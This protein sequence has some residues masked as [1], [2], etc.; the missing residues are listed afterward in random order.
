MM[1]PVVLYLGSGLSYGLG[2]GLTDVCPS[3]SHAEN[4]IEI[5]NKFS[6]CAE[7]RITSTG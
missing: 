6:I 2:L 5:V 3:L 4:S 7:T 1:P